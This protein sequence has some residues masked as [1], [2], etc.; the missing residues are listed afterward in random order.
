ML[1]SQSKDSS[2]HQIVRKF[3]IC[4][5]MKKKRNPPNIKTP[6]T[7]SA[8]KEPGWGNWQRQPETA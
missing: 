8:R 7:L 2:E 4:Y 6:T 5:R 1:E 3:V